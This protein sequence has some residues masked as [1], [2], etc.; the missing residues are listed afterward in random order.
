MILEATT[1][2]INEN[3]SSDFENN[4]KKVEQVLSKAEGYISHELQKCMESKNQYLV[5]IKWQNLEA[6]T[7]K[8]Q[9]SDLFIDLGSLIGKYF[10]TQPV[11][12]HYQLIQQ[13]NLII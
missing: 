10:A 5:L 6:Y 1:I 8:F 4:F 9:Q 2:T 11:V 12:Q 13:S 3:V 7:I